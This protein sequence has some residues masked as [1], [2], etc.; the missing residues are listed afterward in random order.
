MLDYY[1]SRSWN[2]SQ[3]PLSEYSINDNEDIGVSSDLFYST[4]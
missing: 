3:P 4:D 1:F 2:C